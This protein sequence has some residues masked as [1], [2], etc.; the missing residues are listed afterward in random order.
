MRLALSG[1]G[2]GESVR[3]FVRNAPF[4]QGLEEMQR[5]ARWLPHA[6]RA[7]VKGHFN[8]MSF[9]D[10]LDLEASDTVFPHPLS[11]DTAWQVEKIR[12]QAPVLR[13]YEASATLASSS[14]LPLVLAVHAKSDF[15]ATVKGRWQIG[16]ESAHA[17][18]TRQSI[19]QIA[20]QGALDAQALASDLAYLPKEWLQK[21][22]PF[23]LSYIEKAGATTRG[24]LNMTLPRSRF[25]LET[26]QTIRGE[27]VRISGNIVPNDNNAKARASTRKQTH[28]QA[29][30]W[31]IEGTWRTQGKTSLVAERG[32][33]KPLALLLENLPILEGKTKTKT[34]RSSPQP[35]QG[36]WRLSLEGEELDLS[37]WLAQ[38]PKP[39]RAF[40]DKKEEDAP[41]PSLGWGG[42]F[43]LTFDARLKKL[44]LQKP[45][46]KPAPKSA[47]KSVEAVRAR[48]RFQQ[49]HARLRWQD[50]KI[51]NVSFSALSPLFSRSPR[52]QRKQARRLVRTQVFYTLR[53]GKELFSASIEDLGSFLHQAL[54]K[55]IADGG[56][57]QLSFVRPHWERRRPKPHFEGYAKVR[58]VTLYELPLL[59]KILDAADFISVFGKGIRGLDMSSDLQMW[60]GILTL[61]EF[62][63]SNNLTALT[64][65]GS[66][67]LTQ[68]KLDL[69]GEIAS[70][71][72]VSKI[73]RN[74]PLIGTI[75][76][77]R[78]KHNLFAFS[79][80]AKGTWDEPKVTASPFNILLPGIVKIANPLQLLERDDILK[81]QVQQRRQIA[82][83]QKSET[84]QDDVKEEV[85]EEANKPDEQK[86]D[87]K[88]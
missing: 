48:D 35:A 10:Q 11:Y 47:P 72:F 71:H 88:K 30:P 1:A 14:A 26:S 59:L 5:S 9:L 19:Q 52:R 82:E 68:R 7:T 63:L 37:R 81:A 3:R 60:N 78:K 53:E 33:G 67:D 6:P 12:L 40:L 70:L 75:V 27:P 55:S 61:K 83:E 39:W 2:E 76:V 25:R 58:N 86:N 29:L 85:K 79:Y 15:G 44:L 32:G 65:N 24:S 51:R 8:M 20:W 87:P 13:F 31:Q 73:L 62:R 34:K 64:A 23:S 18:R 38:K 41:I 57:T 77:G 66:L 28:T 45:T 43:N 84:Q 54:G 17:V 49:V 16:V 42:R 46:S 56:R 80:E 21:N 69:R 74:I 22:F 50:E 4:L 36:E